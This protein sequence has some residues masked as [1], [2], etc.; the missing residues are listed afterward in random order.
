MYKHPNIILNSRAQGMGKNAVMISLHKGYADY[1]KF[2]KELESDWGIHMDDWGSMLVD[3]TGVVLKPLSLKYL[4][5]QQETRA[6]VGS[7]ISHKN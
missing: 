2:T 5:E 1:A 3:L 7:P 4:G 6:H